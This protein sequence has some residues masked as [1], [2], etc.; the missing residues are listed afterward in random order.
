MYNENCLVCLRM[1]LRRWDADAD[2]DDNIQL[3]RYDASSSTSAD[4]DAEDESLGCKP[5][6]MIPFTWCIYIYIYLIF[7]KVMFYFPVAG[8]KGSIKKVC[9]GYVHING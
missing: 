8:A 2:A 6:G 9:F 3:V 7:Q 4:S 5:L 1:A